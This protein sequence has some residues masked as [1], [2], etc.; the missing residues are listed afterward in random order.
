LTPRLDHH[1]L[2]NP[3]G[4]DTARDASAWQQDRLT[5]LSNLSIGH[6]SC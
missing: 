5:N 6:F 3:F 2:P 4:Y 1:L